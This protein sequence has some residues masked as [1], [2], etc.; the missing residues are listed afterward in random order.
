MGI[1]STECPTCHEI[2]YWY[3]GNA[4]ADQRCQNCKKPKSQDKIEEKKM[5]YEQAHLDSLNKVISVQNELIT[6]LKAEV[7]RLRVFQY[8][9]SSPITYP[10]NPCDQITYTTSGGPTPPITGGTLPLGSQQ[11]STTDGTELHLDFSK[12]LQ[13]TPRT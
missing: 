1:Y 4:S 10:T 6:F 13:G 12:T 11:L 8:T 7:E 9:N 3:S 5:D 2:Y